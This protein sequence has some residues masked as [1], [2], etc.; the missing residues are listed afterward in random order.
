ALTSFGAGPAAATVRAVEV[1]PSA[2]A[3]QQALPGP[4]DR[5]STP[6]SQVSL[7][8]D[9]ALKSADLTV[10]GPAGDA[11]SGSAVISGSTITQRLVTGLPAGVYTVTYTAHGT[12][13][14]AGS[15]YRFTLAAASSSPT[16]TTPSVTYSPGGSATGSAATQAGVGTSGAAATVVPSSTSA[17]LS[18]TGP[19][20]STATTHERN[21]PTVTGSVTD[22]PSGSATAR[23]APDEPEAAHEIKAIAAASNTIG[24]WLIGIAVLLQAGASLWGLWKWRN[25]PAPAHR[26]DELDEDD[27]LVTDLH[28]AASLANRPWTGEFPLPRNDP[29]GRFPAIPPR[30]PPSA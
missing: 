21:T 14:P 16:P 2:L 1:A 5:L 24:A 8:F 18:S 17:G 7:T 22:T 25:T 19:R 15:S 12:G 9:Q 26:A 23:I 13:R 10:S 29:D 30:R 6:P 11:T 3:L 27:L 20:A 4:G 28:L